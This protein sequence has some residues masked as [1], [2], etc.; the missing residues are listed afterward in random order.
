MF[1]RILFLLIFSFSGYGQ[2]D[3]PSKNE[4]V[5]CEYNS[6][7]AFIFTFDPGPLQDRANQIKEAV[8]E[9][10][11]QQV[12]YAH[13][14]ILD[15]TAFSSAIK[16]KNDQRKNNSNCSFNGLKARKDFDQLKSNCNFENIRRKCKEV[17]D[18][19]LALTCGDKS[20][21]CETGGGLYNQAVDYAQ[22]V[23]PQ[24]IVMATNKR[25]QIAKVLLDLKAGYEDCAKQVRMYIVNNRPNDDRNEYADLNF[26]TDAY[27]I[28]LDEKQKEMALENCSQESID[29]YV[30]NFNRMVGRKGPQ[31]LYQEIKNFHIMARVCTLKLLKAFNALDVALDNYSPQ[32]QTAASSDD[33]LTLVEQD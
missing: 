20:K 14:L 21:P 32:R 2:T 4:I 26:C 10:I 3:G 19:T 12:G 8:R 13:A 31:K 22:N 24:T 30:E 5:D 9:N 16:M 1:L 27:K 25:N 11:Y 33:P 28:F 15:N 23:T 7:Q 29:E 18:E 6:P 17:K